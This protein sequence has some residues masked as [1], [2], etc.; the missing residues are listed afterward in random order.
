MVIKIL[1]VIYFYKHFWWINGYTRALKLTQTVSPSKSIMWYG[2]EDNKGNHVFLH[3]QDNSKSCPTFLGGTKIW[4][5][6]DI[7]MTK[8]CFLGNV[9]WWRQW[10]Q[11]CLFTQTKQQVMSHLFGCDKDLTWKGFENF[12][13][14]MFMIRTRRAIMSFP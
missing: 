10:G 14:E 1:I 3:R 12:S 7:D 9:Q 11:S 8:Q 13:W 2:N 6:K 4:H 5:E